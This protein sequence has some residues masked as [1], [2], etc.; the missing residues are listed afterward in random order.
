MAGEKKTIVSLLV[1][2]GAS[3]Q[4]IDEVR[5]ALVQ[6]GEAGSAAAS[7]ITQ[8]LERIESGSAS[9]MGKL[10]SGSDVSEASL[11]KLAAQYVALEEAA[12]QAYGSIQQAPQAVQDAVA[13]AE[14]QIV[15]VN[16]AVV[17][18]GDKVAE[19]TDRFRSMA[20]ASVEASKG[21]ADALQMVTTAAGEAANAAAK[22]GEAS[23][24]A[25]LP[26]PDVKRGFLSIA[27]AAQNM[28][29]SV[30]RG[31]TRDEEGG[32]ESSRALVE[33]LQNR[34]RLKEAI[35]EE[36]GAME[37]ADAATRAAYEAW[38]ME[39]QRLTVH[40]QEMVN[41]QRQAAVATKEGGEQFATIG[42]LAEQAGKHFGETGEKIGSAAGQLGLLA[43]MSAHLQKSF[44]GLKLNELEGGLGRTAIQ[45]GLVAA[46]LVASVA[47]GEKLAETNKANDES[48]QDLVKDLKGWVSV[49]LG[50]WFGRY[51]A[52]MQ[53]FLADLMNAGIATAD[54]FKAIESGD[55]DAA[56]A[57]VQKVQ[58][59]FDG[60]VDEVAAADTAQQR[61]AT[62]TR[63]AS[64]ADE[65]AASFAKENAEMAARVAT[66]TDA[67]RAAVDKRSTSQGK[68][69]L[70][71]HEG[72]TADLDASHAAAAAAEANAKTAEKF[73]KTAEDIA[74]AKEMQAKNAKEAVDRMRESAKATE[75]DSEATKKAI[76]TAAGLAKEKGI[77]AEA[78]KL[79]ADNL[80]EA[81]AQAKE[82]AKQ[83]EEA[84]KA[85][86]HL[87]GALQALTDA[88]NLETGAHERKESAIQKEIDKLQE[89]LKIN[90]KLTDSDRSR[91][92]EM[93]SVAKEIDKLQQQQDALTAAKKKEIDATKEQNAAHQQ[94][95]S[96]L[97]K[98]IDATGSLYIA[99]HR[100]AEAEAQIIVVKS[101]Q[102]AQIA[103][104]I[105]LRRDQL[106]ALNKTTDATV[107]ATTATSKAAITY[108]AATG[109]YTNL[110]EATSK[111]GEAAKESTIHYDETTR[112]W[113]NVK[114]AA[115]DVATATRKT[116]D[117]VEE[118]D[119]FWKKFND[120]MT[121]MGATIVPHFS[122]SIDV[123][124]KA[125]AAAN[126]TVAAHVLEVDKL[127]SAFR[128]ASAGIDEM[129]GK[130][131]EVIAHL[132]D[133]KTHSEAAT[134]AV[135]KLANAGND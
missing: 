109:S 49:D 125:I 25:A 44:E 87:V 117:A 6:S 2:P 108:D 53:V 28:A 7:S 112:S 63:M 86:E 64:N 114:K 33:V 79:A 74:K 15:S 4:N 51:Q 19:A 101:G 129:K 16:T 40:T 107:N 71:V 18:M 50:G 68:L 59:A 62:S 35:V 81:A 82:V 134:V 5:E 27:D 8:G 69:T 20:T 45:A 105:E 11:R 78:A 21:A 115:E 113:T 55:S 80:K 38:D 116:G 100:Q 31:W 103:A 70:A 84:A 76:E 128:T 130:L 102:S 122:D 124:A 56:I 10:A 3:K 30:S 24:R 61:R 96:D 36:F 54:F 123:T 23:E 72:T 48:I 60:L 121:S 90:E 89:E 85:H 133:I 75:D 34:L 126:P 77:L 46:T 111:A 67:A 22:M 106:V 92:T 119:P 12:V 88:V 13:K 32:R 94:S 120:Y 95:A 127:G 26:L 91:I 1:D 99:T 132:K 42:L 9:A 131:A 83:A 43:S 52:W 41:V 17:A 118:A 58:H 47:A 66:A 65:I 98:E 73:A 110:S 97:Q 14:G 39:V 29:E 135:E 93:I 104:E 57:A 37:N